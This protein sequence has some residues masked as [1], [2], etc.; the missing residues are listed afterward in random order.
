M[1]LNLSYIAGFFDG[2]GCISLQARHGLRLILTNTRLDVLSAIQEFFEG[3]GRIKVR[4]RM[5]GERGTRPCYQWVTWMRDAEEILIALRPHL[6]LKASEADVGLEYMALIQRR[7]PG[8]PRGPRVI[9]DEVWSRRFD[10]SAQLKE[11]KRCG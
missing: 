3:K 7:V 1:R 2:E 6:L 11:L 9:P 5:P 10:L 4:I 8:Q